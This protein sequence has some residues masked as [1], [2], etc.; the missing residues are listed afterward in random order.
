M[1]K[2]GMITKAVSGFY[3]V[4][5]EGKI[6]SCRARGIF[7]KKGVTPLVG[8][9]VLFEATNPQEGIIDEIFPRKNELV[10]PP[11][12][13]MDQALLVFSVTEPDFSPLLLD[14]FLVHTEKVGVPAVICLTKTDLPFD[15]GPIENYMSSYQSIGYTVILASTKNEAGLNEI[16][17]ALANR[18]TVFAGQSGV[19]KSSLLN[20]IMPN[21]TLETGEIST[22]LGRGRHTTRHVELIPIDGGGQVADTPGFSQLDFQS[23]EAGELGGLFVEIGRAAEGCKFR[24]CLH[25]KEPGCAVKSA[26]ESGEISSFRYDHYLAFLQEIQERKRRY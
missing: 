14:K 10:R 11:I 13:N 9:H 20:A 15:L 4:T 18:V 22:R 6:W 19:G 23:I 21:L 7:R 16:R 25:I 17:R 5:S 3:Y 24:G 8:D 12:A 1:P 2:Q 26:L